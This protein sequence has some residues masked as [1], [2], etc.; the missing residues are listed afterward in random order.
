MNNDDGS[1]TLR[2]PKLLQQL[3]VEYP[4]SNRKSKY[5]ALSTLMK[6]TTN[7]NEET[8]D[9]LRF[10]YLRLLGQLSYLTNSRPDIL[11][12]VSYG[13]TKGANPTEFDYQILLLIVN[14]L[15]Q[16]QDHGLTL[17]PR[18]P[19]DDGTLNLTAYVD[20]A[21]MSHSDASS[22]TGYCIGLGS[23][24]PSSFFMSKSGKQK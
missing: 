10:R 17:F 22:H 1:L 23:V 6:E 16:T 11:T 20:A 2:Q 3:L 7:D 8:N 4:S 24:N 12:A 18:R 19:N 9:E 5:P 14:Y 13:A 21:F 15:R